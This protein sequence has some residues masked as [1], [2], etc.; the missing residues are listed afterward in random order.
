MKEPS[1]IRIDGNTAF[2]F[3][4]DGFEAA[5]DAADIEL[6]SPYRWTMLVGKHGHAYAQCS[7]VC[8][9]QTLMH[10]L[11]LNAPRGRWVDHED[12]DGL[13]NRRKNIRICTPAQNIANKVVERRNKLGTKGVY[14]RK[15]RFRAVIH[16]AGKTITL[17]SFM[18]ENEAAAAY[19]GAAKALWGEF[20]KK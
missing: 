14:K 10:R 4:R 2:V 15:G 19:R 11:I 5:I 16:S 3:L 1:A 12:G 6:V 8:G 9:K 7:N 18:T 20:A 13:N 17:G